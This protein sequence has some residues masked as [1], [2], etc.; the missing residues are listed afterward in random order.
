MID[1][2]E[3]DSVSQLSHG[4]WGALAV[5]G[6]IALFNPGWHWIIGIALAVTLIAGV[7]EFWYDQRFETAEVRGSNM[8]DFMFYCVG[9]YGALFLYFLTHL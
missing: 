3:F 9:I 1:D 8:R 6:P 7:K 4:G 5:L 2:K